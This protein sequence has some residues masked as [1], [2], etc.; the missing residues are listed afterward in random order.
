MRVWPKNSWVSASLGTLANSFSIKSTTVALSF[1]ILAGTLD[2]GPTT[3]CPCKKTRPWPNLSPSVKTWSRV[4]RMPRFLERSFTLMRLR[5]QIFH[6]QNSTVF[7]FMAKPTHAARRGQ[8]RLLNYL[9]NTAQLGLRY[10][11]SSLNLNAF[12]DSDW[13]TCPTTRRSITG[14]L[15][16]LAS[17]PMLPGCHDVNR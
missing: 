13:A 7:Q 15:V 6:M 16:F 14:N 3:S 8:A 5:V 10:H 12:T 9:Q 17:A 4:L 1:E 2:L 11:G